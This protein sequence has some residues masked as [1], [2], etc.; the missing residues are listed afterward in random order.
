MSMRAYDAIV[1]KLRDKLRALSPVWIGASVAMFF[2]GA[3]IWIAYSYGFFLSQPR[4]LSTLIGAVAGILYY[5]SYAA[6]LVMGVSLLF[7]FPKYLIW[8]VIASIFLIVY[9]FDGLDLDESLVLAAYLL[10]FAAL[11]GGT[12]GLLFARR[13]HG[14]SRL[15]QICVMAS[16]L[17][18]V[19]GL[20][21]VSWW[22]ESDGEASYY[23]YDASS[24]RR[25]KPSDLPDPSE[26]GPHA[27]H[28][29]SYGSGKDK[30]RPEYGTE[31][32]IITE[33]VDGSDFVSRWTGW[34]GWWRTYYWGFD[35]KNLPR[36]ALVWY[37]EGEG[38][39]P[40][41]LI[42]HGNTSMEIYSEPGYAYLGELLA[43]RGYIV[44]SVDEN[45]LNSSW[46]GLWQGIGGNN[47]RAW[48]L[49]EHLQLWREWNGSESSP[50]FNKV[51]LNNIGLM[52][53]SRGGEAIAL[54]ATF[55]RLPYYPDDCNITFDYN[56]NIRSLV[57]I[58]PVDGQ[59]EPTGKPNRLKNI[60]YLLLHG[61]SD[62]DV[63]AYEGS[64]QYQRITFDEDSDWYKSSA[65]IYGANHGQF[66]TLWGRYDQKPLEAW[67]LN[68]KPLIPA[69]DQRKIA[70]VYISAFL[71]STL[72]GVEGYKD[73]LR[74]HR[75]GKAW[76]PDTIYI[77]SYADG[78]YRYISDFE[79]DIDPSTTTI[80]AGK[81]FGI[82][83]SKWREHEVCLKYGCMDTNAVFLGWDF[84][85]EQEPPSYNIVLSKNALKITS[86]SSLVFS[87]AD[88]LEHSSEEGVDLTIEVID[89][90]GEVSSL[91]LSHYSDLQ[92]SL[93]ACI[94]KS[95]FLDCKAPSDNVY[96][97]FVFPMVD[98]VEKNADFDP[99]RLSQIRFVF[100]RTKSWEVILDDVCIRP[101]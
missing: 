73:L 4:W 77:T 14:F 34:A 29:L 36:N 22:A 56:F 10:P 2:T 98:F 71:D 46:H 47:G 12:I 28:H 45:F 82:N 63:V 24:T 54:A 84:D 62:G 92:P 89:E 38:P 17:V 11:I 96:Q 27:V 69:A 97:S 26:I 76:L 65:Y 67:L 83:L 50:F 13:W 95:F 99:A 32:G 61:S 1:E 94:W 41:V 16:L 53:H 8:A 21:I 3:L 23:P 52:G 78:T 93:R 60:N 81:L 48:M 7:V 68:V 33:S 30:W 72:K 15:A 90:A 86:D 74:D 70:Q 64:S 39:F 25:V 87:M 80:K 6:L 58:A 88:A 49:L 57:A 100:N 37:P 5:S 40:L 59:Y 44:A 79:E 55:N 51:D 9:G 18:G 75:V 20:G 19:L 42:V 85:D 66:N 91:P 35:T 43:S 31:V 101:Y